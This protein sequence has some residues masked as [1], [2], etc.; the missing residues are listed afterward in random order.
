MSAAAGGVAGAGGVA[1]HPR[2]VLQA[3]GDSHRSPVR[4]HP[5]SVHT[6]HFTP[7][8]MSWNFAVRAGLMRR[9]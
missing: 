5:I 1:L 4:R 9:S 8:F 7:P 3:G 2:V 6:L